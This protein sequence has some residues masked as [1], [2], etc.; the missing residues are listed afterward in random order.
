LL[1]SAHE[2][3][4]TTKAMNTVVRILCIIYGCW[5]GLGTEHPLNGSF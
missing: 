1:E 4:I 3:A 5:R 2:A